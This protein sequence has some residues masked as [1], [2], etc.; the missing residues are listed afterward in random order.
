MRWKAVVPLRLMDNLPH[1]RV[2]QGRPFLRTGVDYAGPILIRTAKR[3]HQ[4]HK[5]FIVVFVCFATKAVH[6]KAASDYSA[7]AFLA[8]FR[9][10]ISRRGLCDEMHSDCGINFTDAS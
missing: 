5:G 6:L 1:E 4:A 9:R 7:D 3:N 8:A 10:F 2:T